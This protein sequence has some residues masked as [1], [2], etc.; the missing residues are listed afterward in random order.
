MSKSM[1]DQLANVSRGM[2]TLVN[3][4]SRVDAKTRDILIPKL[5]RKTLN[6]IVG[7]AEENKLTVGSLSEVSARLQG[8]RIAVNALNT[9]FTKGEVDFAVLALNSDKIMTSLMP[10]R[11]LS[12]HQLVYAHTAASFALLC[13]P[14]AAMVMANRMKLP[15]TQLLAD[16]EEASGG[17]ACAL[18]EDGS[19]I[20]L[21]P[22]HHALLIRGY[23]LLVWDE[24][25][26]KILARALS[27]NRWCE[28]AL[29]GA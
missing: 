15:D 7:N 25:S 5:L 13:Q 19:L 3:T 14:V 26:D 17:V 16:V 11:H 22:Q 27:V 10:S 18:P 8:N 21:L 2:V 9:P 12:W 28:I 23:G 24:N 1:F 20:S 4:Q 29:A 6:E